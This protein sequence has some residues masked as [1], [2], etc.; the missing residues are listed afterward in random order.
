ME[1][2]RFKFSLYPNLNKILADRRASIQGDQV[3]ELIRS[4]IQNV[5]A[6]GSGVERVFFPDRSNQIP[7]RPAVTFVVLSPD[8]SVKDE[9]KIYK[10]I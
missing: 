4:E 9:A 5:F 6:S 7:D 2:N 1:N 3:K 10:F 8:Q